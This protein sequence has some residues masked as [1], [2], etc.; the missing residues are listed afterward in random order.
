MKDV[1]NPKR[2]RFIIDNQYEVFP[3]NG[4][5]LKVQY[6]QEADQIFFRKKVSDKIVFAKSCCEGVGY[7]N[8]LPFAN[9]Y[10]YI[11]YGYE[12]YTCKKFNIEIQEQCQDYTWKTVYEGYFT[13]YDCEWDLDNCVIEAKLTTDDI[14]NCI[15]TKWDLKFNIY[16]EHPAQQNKLAVGSASS[17]WQILTIDSD[18]EEPHDTSD[19]IGTYPDIETY[20]HVLAEAYKRCAICPWRAVHV[21]ARECSFTQIGSDWTFSDDE[22]LWFRPYN[23]LTT[24]RIITSANWNNPAP[25]D[26]TGIW[27]PFTEL[28]EDNDYFYLNTNG[29]NYYHG[30]K[31]GGFVKH[32]D[33]MAWIL[34]RLDCNAVT[35]YDSRFFNAP[36]NYVTGDTPNPLNNVYIT[37]KSNVIRH[38]SSQTATKFEFSMKEYLG[39][40]RHLFQA[41]WYIDGN[42][43]RLEHLSDF[44]AGVGLDLTA[45]AGGVFLEG[46]T[47][48]TF[49]RNDMP[50]R[51]EWAI[52]DD[53]D[54]WV[55]YTT[56]CASVDS[57]KKYNEDQIYTDVQRLLGNEK[58]GL[59]GVVFVISDSAGVVQNQNN[60]LRMW[61]CAKKYWA[62]ERPFMK[63]VY[64]RNENVNWT[65]LASN[66]EQVEISLPYCCSDF[67]PIQRVRTQLGIG[68][69]KTAEY[70]ISN[71][72]LSLKLVFDE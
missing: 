16:G 12:H 69:V 22:G 30:L 48:F 57:I 5:K 8:D 2:Q 33:V 56:K 28:N 3:L 50:Y 42:T 39:W 7:D 55:E 20:G 40:V 11:K 58:D 32:A 72:Y 15:L 59:D 9:G 18:D 54:N 21:Y 4:N 64:K 38:W 47:K 10:N 24:P 44:T 31:A 46:K 60:E 41:F 62:H 36:V 35:L 51:E 37:Q 29:Y 68:K 66:K 52:A 65:S 53:K 26:H 71:G 1:L 67:N 34:D 6:A 43:I 45:V 25:P 23:P 17:F 19:L 70:L 14:Y 49:A 63:G 27:N 13:A 61:N